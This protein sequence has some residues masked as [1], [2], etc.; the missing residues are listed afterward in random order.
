MQR[1]RGP[2]GAGGRGLPSEESGDGESGLLLPQ[3]HPF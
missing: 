3:P 1:D 2:A